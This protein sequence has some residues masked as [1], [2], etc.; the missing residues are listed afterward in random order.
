M[1]TIV[2][3]IWI[4]WLDSSIALLAK[5]SPEL[6]TQF[7]YV[8]I[9][10]IDSSRDLRTLESIQNIVSELAGFQFLNGWLIATSDSLMPLMNKYNLL[11]GFDE[12]WLFRTPPSIVLPIDIWITGPRE[13]TNEVPRGLA[14][15]MTTSGCVLGLG[16]GIGLNYAT[17]EEFIA[18]ALEEK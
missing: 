18:S 14:E 3:G 1:K 9:T 16:D 15:W 7:P 8:L 17:T 4:G 13:I 2:D 10:S 5:D 6:L 12:M 11:N